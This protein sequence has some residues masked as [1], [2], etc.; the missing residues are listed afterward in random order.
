MRPS[1]SST[2]FSS[3][4]PP[5]PSLHE[6]HRDSN[7]LLLLEPQHI[8]MRVQVAIAT[9][10][11]HLYLARC[12]ARRAARP[13][14]GLHR[15]TV[16]G[17]GEIGADL[18]ALHKRGGDGRGRALLEVAAVAGGQRVGDVLQLPTQGSVRGGRIAADAGERAE[19]GAGGKCKGG[20]KQRGESD[21]GREKQHGWAPTPGRS[22]G[23]GSK[24]REGCARARER[25]RERG[26]ERGSRGRGRVERVADGLGKV[27]ERDGE[28]GGGAGG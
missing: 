19:G 16:H 24:G 20:I 11:Q 21:E 26:G 1:F 18:D 28:C 14:A 15:G 8:L 9:G 2:L 23:R 13:R 17:R 10:V 3:L 22:T 6:T 12:L 4:S 5:L 25:E 27:S 7:R